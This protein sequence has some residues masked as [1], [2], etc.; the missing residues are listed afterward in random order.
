MGLVF[1][2]AFSHLGMYS[3]EIIIIK[4]AKICLQDYSL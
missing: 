1:D 3:E 2:P 4:C